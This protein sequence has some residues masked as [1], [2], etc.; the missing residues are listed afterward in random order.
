MKCGIISTTL[1]AKTVIS[2]EEFGFTTTENVVS[3]VCCK[4]KAFVCVVGGGLHQW[5]VHDML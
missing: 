1:K 2:K 3:E 4:T 5:N